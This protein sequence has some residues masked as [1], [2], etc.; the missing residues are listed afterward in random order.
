MFTKTLMSPTLKAH[1]KFN[2][3]KMY[4]QNFN[5]TKTKNALKIKIQEIGS[6]C[7]NLDIF[8]LLTIPFVCLN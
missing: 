8:L 5:V 3:T 6:D 2:V 1:Q 4:N 7:L